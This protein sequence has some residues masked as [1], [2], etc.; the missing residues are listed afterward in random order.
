M[1]CCAAAV[2]LMLAF[3]RTGVG[4]TS[5]P[6]PPSDVQHFG[7][8]VVVSFNEE[9]PDPVTY[10]GDLLGGNHDERMRA[11]RAMGIDS[12]PELQ[13]L[14]TT[15]LADHSGESDDKAVMQFI[16]GGMLEW[17]F[18]ETESKQAVLGAEFDEL[19]DHPLEL[20]AVFSLKD[21]R[22]RHV[23]TMGCR[24]QMTDD[25][26]PFNPHPGRPLPPQE[27]V[28]SLGERN[29]VAHTYRRE[30]IRFRLRDGRLW[31]LIRFESLSEN[32]PNG[33]QPRAAC[34]FVRSSLEKSRLF[35]DR[36]DEVPGYVVISWDGSESLGSK[37]ILPLRN[38]RCSS[39]TWDEITFSYIPSHLKPKSCGH[40]PTPISMPATAPEKAPTGAGSPIHP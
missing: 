31:P 4:E 23:A 36:G 35:N 40:F 14:W 37:G 38:P 26:E 34:D 39:Y 12:S 8:L 28:V 29:V 15:F 33:I 21:G 25:A 30:E 9:A 17:N 24:C 20:S 27:W 10:R 11:L 2:V 19:T 5:V 1:K 16:S 22:W 6:S 7:P 32:C 18:G 13:K 3:A